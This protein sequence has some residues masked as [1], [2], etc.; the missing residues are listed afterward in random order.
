MEHLLEIRLKGG[1][2]APDQVVKPL[3]FSPARSAPTH[4]II[5][6]TPPQRP[7]AIYWHIA[8]LPARAPFE[9]VSLSTYLRAKVFT[10][11]HPAH[12]RFEKVVYPDAGG[13]QK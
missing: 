13:V 6:R 1:C 8:K 5:G 10:L 7:C 3:I 9:F 11:K 2:Q 4:T 12:S